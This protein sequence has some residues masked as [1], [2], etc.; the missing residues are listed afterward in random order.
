MSTRIQFFAPS[1]TSWIETDFRILSEMGEVQFVDIQK[2]SF[3]KW[4]FNHSGFDLGFFW[5]GSL[6]FLP[7]LLVAKILRKKIVIVAGGYDVNNIPELRYGAFQQGMI[8]RFLRRLTFRFADK[9]LAVSKFA[10]KIAKANLPASVDQIEQVYLPIALPNSPVTPWSER[11]RQ[12]LFL[13]SSDE[14][15][16]LVKGIDLIPMICRHL[17]DVS[18]KLAGKLEDSVLAKL[19]AENIE[20][21]EI[22]GMVP[23]HSKEFFALLNSSRVICCPSRCESFGAAVLDAALMGCWPVAFDVGSL[24]EVMSRIGTLVPACDVAK[25]V[26]VIREKIQM[27]DYNSSAAIQ[28]IRSSFGPDVRKVRLKKVVRDTLAKNRFLEWLRSISLKSE[29]IYPGIRYRIIRD[30]LKILGIKKYEFEVDFFGS[31]YRGNIEN[32]IDLHVFFLGAYETGILQFMRSLLSKDS[33]AFDVGANMGHHSLFLARYCKTLESFEPYEPVR[34]ICE[35]RLKENH[36]ENV[37]VHSIGLGDADGMAEF[38]EPPPD[39]LGIG[40]FLPTHS[41]FNRSRGLKLELRKG[42]SFVNELGLKRV[43][44]IKIDVEDAEGSVL[45]GLKETMEKFSPH[46]IVEVCKANVADPD[47]VKLFP[48]GYELFYIRNGFRRQIQ[49]EPYVKSLQP[50]YVYARPSTGSRESFQSK[51]SPTK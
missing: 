9:I 10:E 18:F 5:F 2:T 47:F 7:Y 48:P 6:R 13:I 4:L 39:N 1:R 50:A 41:A 19:K 33:V 22:L 36:I 42:D 38:Y 40:S 14:T 24:P 37:H 44:L 25:M 3:W 45:G 12:V 32:H 34:R 20:N 29:F 21:L 43:D 17:P 46:I 11:P 23:F 30:I 31:R 49:L 26:K 51:T 35:N 16:R 8:S 15:N 28:E 27:S